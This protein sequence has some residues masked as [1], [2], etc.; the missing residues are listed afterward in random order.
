MRGE[1]HESWSPAAGKRARDGGTEGRREKR[2]ERGEREREERRT[3]GR[4]G[5]F[6]PSHGVQSLYLLFLPFPLR[7]FDEAI[8]KCILQSQDIETLRYLFENCHPLSFF[9][10]IRNCFH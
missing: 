2:R 4:E 5:S 6:P 10:E 8:S 9:A 7:V 1:E 3:G